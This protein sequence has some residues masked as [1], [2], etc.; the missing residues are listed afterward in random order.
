MVA[1]VAERAEAVML[2]KESSA[3]PTR[4]CNGTTTSVRAR[5]PPSWYG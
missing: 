2:K 3:S 1:S 4:N 5:A